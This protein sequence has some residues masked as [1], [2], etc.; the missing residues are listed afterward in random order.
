MRLPALALLILCAGCPLPV[1]KAIGSIAQ[2]VKDVCDAATGPAIRS[3]SCPP[4]RP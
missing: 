2:A 3:P 4:P 1:V